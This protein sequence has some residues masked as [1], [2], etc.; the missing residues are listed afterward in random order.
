MCTLDFYRIRFRLVAKTEIYLPPH[1]AGNTLRGMF[2]TILRKSACFPECTDARSC[3]RRE[4]C[5]YAKIFE[6]G[7]TNTAA[8]GLRDWPRPFVFRTA[9]LNGCHIQADQC[10]TFELNLFQLYHSAIDAI[11][12][13]FA[14]LGTEGLGAARGE[15]ELHSVRFVTLAGEEMQ[16][17]AICRLPLYSKGAGASKIQVVFRSPTEIKSNNEIATVPAFP[18]LVTRIRERVETLRRLYGGASDMIPATDFIER[19]HQIQTAVCDLKHSSVNRRSSKT[20]QRHPIGG[21]VGRA[22]YEGKLDEFLP[23]LEAAVF[24]G[25]GRHTAWGNGELEVTVLK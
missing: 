15:V 18:V 19:A 24:T 7:T 4:T 8:E 5:P 22:V 1:K 23:Y 9:D 13:C 16:P 6:P 25:V 11:V 20:G 10:F 21:F 17:A 14:E 2:G 12:R 3:P